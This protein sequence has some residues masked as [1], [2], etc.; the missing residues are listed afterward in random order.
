MQ[1]MRLLAAKSVYV[2]LYQEIKALLLAGIS[3]AHGRTCRPQR[4][5]SVFVLSLCHCLMRPTK[6]PAK[7]V[8][9]HTH[10]TKG[11]QIMKCNQFYL[12]TV[13]HAIVNY[14]KFSILWGLENNIISCVCII[15]NSRHLSFA[16]L[17]GQQIKSN[18]EFCI[19]REKS[20]LIPVNRARH[21]PFW[22]SLWVSKEGSWSEVPFYGV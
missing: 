2:F 6:L 9:A 14:C 16:V 4:V 22:P 10:Y 17:C 11:L 21:P 3:K 7:I 8:L 13:R 5:N 1:W 18:A 15:R 19:I 12:C 20:V